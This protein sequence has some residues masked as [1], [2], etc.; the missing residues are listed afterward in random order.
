[1]PAETNHFLKCVTKAI[2]CVCV[3]ICVTCMSARNALEIKE[4]V[5]IFKIFDCDCFYQNLF[6]QENMKADIP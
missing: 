6:E 3:Y 1:M 4:D 2:T 5:D